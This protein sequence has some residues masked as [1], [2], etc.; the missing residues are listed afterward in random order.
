[1]MSVQEETAE[2]R[3]ITDRENLRDVKSLVISSLGTSSVLC[4]QK[5]YVQSADREWQS[6]ET[7]A[8]DILQVINVFERVCERL[9]SSICVIIPNKIYL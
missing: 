3:M 2:C 4:I 7:R 5:A 8:H 9:P 1:M 6:R